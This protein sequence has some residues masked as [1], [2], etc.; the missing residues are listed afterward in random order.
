MGSALIT[1]A[2]RAFD[3]IRAQLPERAVIVRHEVTGRAYNGLL[4]PADSQ[5]AIMEYGELPGYQAS[6]RIKNC[7]LDPRKPQTNDLVIVGETTHKVL[8]VRCGDAMTI[9]DLGDRHA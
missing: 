3:A 6:V 1:A 7:D 5:A 9:L 2:E 4:A 8:N